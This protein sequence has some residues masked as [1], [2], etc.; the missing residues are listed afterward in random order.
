E[1]SSYWTGRAL[2]FIAREP[3]RWLGL[4]GRKAALFV[5]RGAL[6]D[7]DDQYT[8]GDWSTVLALLNP[9]L[10]F[11]LLVPLAVAGIVLAWGRASVRLPIALLGIYTLTGVA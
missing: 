5:N 9:F 2:D 4:L 6:G 7:A 10:T 11:G 1:V 8:Y 3:R